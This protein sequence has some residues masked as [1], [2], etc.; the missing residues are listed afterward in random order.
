MWTAQDLYRLGGNLKA[1]KFAPVAVPEKQ[2]KPIGDRRK[3]TAPYPEK[4]PFCHFQMWEQKGEVVCVAGREMRRVVAKL[5][6]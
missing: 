5:Y 1:D 3:V 2:G 4:D 6:V